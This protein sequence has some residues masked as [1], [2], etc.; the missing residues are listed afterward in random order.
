MTERERS[1]AAGAALVTGATSGI[2]YELAALLARDG[3]RLVLVARRQEELDRV[4]SEFRERHGVT[5]ETV[6][7]E[8]AR[9]AAI[10]ELIGELERREVEVEILI[11]SAGFGSFGPFAQSHPAHE[12]AMIQVNVAALTHLT[13]RLLPGML[14][15][16][17]G[18]IMNLA[19]TAAFQ[20]GPLMAV[21]YASKA[22]VLSFSEA[23]AE[24]LRGTGVT[25]TVL[26]P[27][28][29]ATGFQARA[30]MEA[31]KLVRG[32]GLMDARRVAAVGYAGM[33]AGKT[34][35]IPGALNWLGA[36][37]VRFVPRRA[38]T[39]FVRRIQERAEG[40]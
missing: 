24:E 13:R 21:Y 27:G 9:P 11:N 30:A 14:V 38:A 34:V 22:Y 10:D 8:L 2:G 1:I 37:A 17:R 23:I 39:R 28:P 20:P 15:R 5:A 26:C 4:G 18:R 12:L 33:L 6:A 40:Q 25:V 16:R 35:V 7:A 3:H 19:S 29:T 36:E 31:S 32:G